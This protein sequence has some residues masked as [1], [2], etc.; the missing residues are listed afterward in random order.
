VDHGR[1]LFEAARQPKR[2]AIVEGGQHSDLW[3]RGLWAT[4]LEFLD[5]NGVDT[6]AAVRRIPSR[7]G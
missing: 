7:A 2:L 1:R 6:Q 4:V 3:D 5:E